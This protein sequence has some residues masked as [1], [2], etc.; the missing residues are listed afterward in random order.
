MAVREEAGLL[1]GG[2]HETIT[3]LESLELSLPS[4][5]RTKGSDIDLI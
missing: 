3:V 5:W 1:P 2:E 4:E